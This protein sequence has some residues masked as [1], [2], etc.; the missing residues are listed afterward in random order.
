MSTKEK[1]VP[2][3]KVLAE[4]ESCW[5]ALKDRKCGGLVHTI[6]GQD[7]PVVEK[8]MVHEC[9]ESIKDLAV[10]TAVEPHEAMAR[11]RA[12]KTVLVRRMDRRYM[13]DFSKE[14][15]DQLAAEGTDYVAVDLTAEMLGRLGAGFTHV[16]ARL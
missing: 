4:V 12:I 15:A 8:S 13:G 16:P 10:K 3:S 1:Y 6:G 14:L 2:L 7:H 5:N 11:S 9:L